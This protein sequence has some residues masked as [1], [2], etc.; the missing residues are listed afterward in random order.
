[1]SVDLQAETGLPQVGFQAEVKEGQEAKE[2]CLLIDEDLAVKVLP[3]E[4]TG[5]NGACFSVKIE[6]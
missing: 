6:D 1:M 5:E 4:D 2:P 3:A